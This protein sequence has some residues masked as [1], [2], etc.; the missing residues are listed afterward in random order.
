MTV[1]LETSNIILPNTYLAKVKRK[2]PVLFAGFFFF[3]LL[4][5][6]IQYLTTPCMV[7]MGPPPFMVSMGPRLYGQ[8]GATSVWSVW[9]H[10]CMVSMGPRLYG[11]YGAT[12][13]WSV[14]G[15]VCMVS[16]GSRNLSEVL[17]RIYIMYIYSGQF[18][19]D[20]G[21]VKTTA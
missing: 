16:M 12:S 13:V 1:F 8:Y 3:L 4:Y 5:P 2:T 19:Q 7:S 10:V 15:H 17:L 20:V 11:Q 18:C 14:W 6:T 21:K 9:D